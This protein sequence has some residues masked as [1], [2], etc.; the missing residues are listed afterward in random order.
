MKEEGAKD[1]SKELFLSASFAIYIYVMFLLASLFF[2]LF[3]LN[4]IHF[5]FLCVA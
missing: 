5:T 4:E 2:V 1:M 3:L